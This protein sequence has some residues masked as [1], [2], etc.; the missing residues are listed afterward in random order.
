M[1]FSNGKRIIYAIIEENL[2]KCCFWIIY[3]EI[4]HLEKRLE[5]MLL[6]CSEFD[7]I[8]SSFLTSEEDK[9]RK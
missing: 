8:I 5:S 2:E 4:Y 7:Q 1:G 9:M 6:Y 3:F